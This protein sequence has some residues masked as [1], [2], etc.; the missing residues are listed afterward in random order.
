MKFNEA[1]IN[2]ADVKAIFKQAEEFRSKPR[3]LGRFFDKFKK[4]PIDINDL[5]QA[6]ADEGYPDDTRD[7]A[8]ILKDHGFAEKEINKVFSKIYGDEEPQGSP[9]IQKIADYIKTNGLENEIKAIM[10]R[11][12]GFTESYSRSGKLIVEDIRKVFTNILLED[13]N[14]LDKAVLEHEQKI[15]GRNRKDS[16]T[17]KVDLHDV[18][19]SDQ[20]IT[21]LHHLKAKSKDDINI[22]RIK[23]KVIQSWKRG[24][25]S[26]KHYDK[27]LQGINI[28]IHDIIGK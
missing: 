15:F 8:R 1:Q 22:T 20:Y 25:K 18:I 23:N 7:I 26:R 10:Q 19:K 9:A 13:R 14:N 4:D 2:T 24:M 5:Q 28:K 6:W 27:L 16:I 3:G 17:E 12:Y 21:L 11:D